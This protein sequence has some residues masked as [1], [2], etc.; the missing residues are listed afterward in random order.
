MCR[1]IT[2]TVVSVLLSLPTHA[3]DRITDAQIQQ[4]IDAT[5]VA[6]MIRD[7]AGIGKYLGESF[8]KFVEFP[9]KQWMAKVSVRKDLYLEIIEAGW[10]NDADYF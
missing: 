2:S 6:S 10:A 9:Y 5:D 7:A 3:A 4:V 1:I 8:R